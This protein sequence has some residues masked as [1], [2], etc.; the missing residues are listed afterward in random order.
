[1]QRKFIRKMDVLGRIVLPQKIRNEMCWR[2]GTKLSIGRDCNKLIL[3][4]YNGTCFLEG[5]KKKK[6]SKRTDIIFSR[7]KKVSERCK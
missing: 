4:K 7:S 2:D 3:Q 6:T 1:M 5:A